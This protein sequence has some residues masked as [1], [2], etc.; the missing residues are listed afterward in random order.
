MTVLRTPWVVEGQ[1]YC[2]DHRNPDGSM[3]RLTYV[4]DDYATPQE[5][6][7]CPS[8]DVKFVCHHVHDHGATP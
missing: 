8:D 5:W 1:H 2:P 7:I 3:I 4:E 6:Y